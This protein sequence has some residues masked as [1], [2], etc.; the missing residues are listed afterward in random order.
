MAASVLWKQRWVVASNL[1]TRHGEDIYCSLHRAFPSPWPKTLLCSW[2]LDTAHAGEWEKLQPNCM[3]WFQ[4][5][6]SLWSLWQRKIS[7][8]W[9]FEGWIQI[10]EGIAL[11]ILE[12]FSLEW[13]ILL[14]LSRLKQP[15]INILLN[16]PPR[17][18]F[19]TKL[20]NLWI[21][22]KEPEKVFISQLLGSEWYVKRF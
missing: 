13:V 12:C 8:E 6:W 20:F 14:V 17:S 15:G 3:G 16:A 1:M 9:D 11:I 7:W 5:D 19:D 18:N 10:S 22:L 4:V 21:G 2:A